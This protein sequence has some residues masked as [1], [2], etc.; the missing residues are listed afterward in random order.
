MKNI[1]LI[2]TEKASE[3]YSINGKHKLANSTMAMDWYISSVG[4][5]PHNIYI[6]SDEEIKV[7]DYVIEFQKGNVTGDVYLIKNEYT[8]APDI[9]Q[10]IILTDDKTLIDDGIQEIP[11]EFLGWLVKNPSCEEVEVKKRY[12]DFTVNPFVGYRITIQQEEPKPHS[13]CETPEEK[14]TMNYCD[15]NGCQNRVRHLVEPQEELKQE[16][17]ATEEDAKIFVDAIENPPAPNE[18]LKTA[19]GKQP[20]QETL[21]EAAENYCDI[22]KNQLGNKYKFSAHDRLLYNTFIE[23][24]KSDAARDYW[25]KIFQQEQDKNKYSEEEVQL[26]LSKLLTDIKKGNAG[27]SIKWFKQFKKK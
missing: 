25:F 1:H 18:K 6:T 14:C 27:N 26:I 7:G 8:I 17:I 13:F 15:E 21:E 19:F 3:F 2:P 16:I 10:K 4:Y 22:P 5:K 12:S 23:G 20:K 24:A 9:Q 11:D